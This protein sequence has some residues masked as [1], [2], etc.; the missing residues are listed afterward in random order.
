[1]TV[2]EK[3]DA[4]LSA[5]LMRRSLAETVFAANDNN[6]PRLVTLAELDAEMD[7]ACRSPMMITMTI[8][9]DLWSSAL[10]G[11]DQPADGAQD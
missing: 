11:E 5:T 7:V 6:L 8:R 1:M 2:A 3:L 10:A 9:Y 4:W